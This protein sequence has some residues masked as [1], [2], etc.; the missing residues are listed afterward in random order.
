MH[1]FLQFTAYCSNKSS[2]R[3]QRRTHKN[4]IYVKIIIKSLNKNLNSKSKN[5]LAL[6]REYLLLYYVPL[7]LRWFLST[8]Q[9]DSI[10]DSHLYMTKIISIWWK[11]RLIFKV[12]YLKRA[13]LVL[14]R[15]IPE[16]WIICLEMHEIFV[17]C[18][19]LIEIQ[20]DLLYFS[21]RN[22]EFMPTFV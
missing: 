19:K 4:T 13:I 2:R 22:L 18:V 21:S 5:M 15:T 1:N 3:F 12:H 10:H 20:N 11:D 7:D 14:V 17:E 8:F 9:Y 6:S 16:E